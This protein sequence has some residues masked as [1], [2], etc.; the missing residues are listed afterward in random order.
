MI[1]FNK[2]FLSKKS[3]DYALK[4]ME[5]NF[6]VGDGPFTNLCQN[7]FKE[8]FGF[9]HALLTTSCTHALEM[10]ALLLDFKKGDEIIMPSYTFVSCANAFIREGAR[11]I[12]CDS[13]KD[14]P[15]MDLNHLENLINPNTKAVLAVHYGGASCD[16]ERLAKIVSDN[17]L[18]LIEDAAQAIN[19][20]Y[21]DKPLGSFGDLSTFSFHGTKNISCGEGGLLAI[22]NSDFIERAEIIREKGT[23]R[24]EFIKGKVDKYRW[25]DIG[26][27]YLPSDILAAILYGQIEELD[28]IHNHR[29][30]AW[31][32]YNSEIIIRNNSPF[33]INR[34]LINANHNGHI[35]SITFDKKRERD[36][37]IKY[38]YNNQVQVVSHYQS[39]HNA[40]YYKKISKSIV[41]C[42]YSDRFTN[43]LVRLPL[44][45]GIDD[46]ELKKVI[47]LVNIYQEN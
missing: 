8:K 39:L 4:S 46:Q 34:Y 19:S 31:N 32:K 44:F 47:N 23:N 17:D 33:T 20:F 22:N 9:K 12:F 18:L 42:K 27:S 5:S 28:K 41:D 7:F 24:K 35:F 21:N 14:S 40:P 6:H 3:H 10:C 1:P 45:Q 2:S 16:M 25:V 13:N 30:N 15:N 36:N 26:S 29:M 11:V 37:F 43:G 38:M